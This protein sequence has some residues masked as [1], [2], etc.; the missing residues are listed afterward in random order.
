MPMPR[1]LLPAGF[2]SANLIIYWGGFDTTWKL[3]LAMLLGLVLFAIGAKRAGTGAAGTIRSVRWTFPWLAGHVVIGAVGRYGPGARNILPDWVDVAVVIG[4]A[5]GI[6]Y[7]AV[8]MAMPKEE[9]AAAVAKDAYQID[10]V[11]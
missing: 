2:C 11:P 10:Y 5:L 3:A 6:F 9:T 8:S 7:W 1:V 4:F